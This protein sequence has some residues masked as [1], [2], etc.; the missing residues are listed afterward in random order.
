M[1]FGNGT[2]DL[3][4][5][6]Q[7]V[8]SYSQ[9]HLPLSM[10]AGVH[11][12]FG[13][14][15]SVL[16]DHFS[17]ILALLAPLYWVHSGPQTLLVAQALL[18]AA[19]IPPL[20]V[21]TRRE[22]GA[23]PAYCVVV[24][25]AV[26]WPVAQAV[27]FDFHEVAFVPVLTA[28]LFERFS[29]YRGDAGRW[30]HLVLPAVGLLCV[31]EDMG[32]LVAGFGAAVLVCST[33]WVTPR[34]R[35]ARWLGA[36]FVVGGLVAVVVTIEVILPAF[37][38][39][40]A[41]YWSYGRFGPTMGSAAW[42][43]LTHPGTVATT[44]VQP[45]V[46]THTVVLLLAIAAFA[47]VVSPFLLMVLPLLAERMLSDSPNWWGLAFHYN[48]FLVVALLCAGVDGM[49]RLVRW[50]GRH[51]WTRVN[52]ARP[53][54]LLWAA[55]VLVFGV[56]L[57]ARLRVR[58]TAA[59]RRR[60][61]RDPTV[62]AAEDAVAHVPSGVTVAAAN[63]LGPHLTGRTTVVLWDLVPR[64]TPWVVADVARPVFPFCG[65]VGQQRH[66]AE[67]EADGYRIVFAR[68]RLSRAAPSR[69]AAS[70]CSRAARQAADRGGPDGDP[71]RAV[72]AAG[73]NVRADG[74][75]RHRG[76]GQLPA[77]GPR[78]R[79]QHD[80]QHPVRRRHAGPAL[81][82]VP[83]GAGGGAGRVRR[84]RG[85]QWAAGQGVR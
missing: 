24:G 10:V 75:G 28:V 77:A 6:D 72:G 30:W 38:S 73:R 54:A 59:A 80:G 4:I 49:A 52:W 47:P 71:C 17:P 84:G 40:A 58:P 25:Y 66:V 5:F 62:R 37:G 8:R 32:L 57:G 81:G 51:G 18:F 34:R 67:L 22:L 12:G 9:F 48:A 3:V 50:W 70:V 27:T 65:I 35:E 23:V 29:A 2:Y 60:G 41:F 63:G 1:T 36:G 26:A 21:F 43:M 61:G 45:D 31:K 68:G 33:R 42:D 55:T 20:W 53:F 79:R 46:K 56:C 13:T 16:G 44:L 11:R 78:V 7:A 83:R 15:F 76:R 39:K 85:R 19:A 74:G 69:P 82:P 64:W 14:G